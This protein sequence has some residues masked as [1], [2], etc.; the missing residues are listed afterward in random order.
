[1]QGRT[2]H[3]LRT[4]GIIMNCLEDMP[5]ECTD[6]Y[7]QMKISLEPNSCKEYVIHVRRFFNCIKKEIKEISM[8]DITRYFDKI[9]YKDGEPTSFSY[10]KTTWTALNNFFMFCV[11]SKYLTENPMEN[12]IRPRATDNV[13]HVSLSM[14]DLTKILNKCREGVGGEK[15]LTAHE[16]WGVRDELILGLFM[17]TGMRCAALTEINI[18]DIDFNER[19]LTIIDKRR[20]THIYYLDEKII[21][22]LEEWLD[23]RKELLGEIECD[24]LFISKFKQR[25]NEKGVANL[26]RKYSKEALG[27][28]VSPH[29][30]RGAFVTNFYEASGHDIKATCEAVGHANIATTSIYINRKNNDRKKAMEYMSNSLF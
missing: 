1:M 14:K 5:K 10:R 27:Y 16:T 18:N 8:T 2:E 22:I 24:A 21:D 26:V 20:K 29:K 13:E 4:K 12:I 3:D 17:T 9:E 25:I 15:A 7:Y 6:W 19:K 28:E 23:I 11:K 30:L